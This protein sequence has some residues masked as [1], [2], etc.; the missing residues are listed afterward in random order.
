MVASSPLPQLRPDLSSAGVFLVLRRMRMPLIVLIGIFAVSV[1]G[2][3]LIPGQDAQGRPDRMGIFDSFNHGV[4]T[5]RQIGQ[6]H[7]CHASK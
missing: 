2:L 3:S 4:S 5:F 6:A 1:L 7:G